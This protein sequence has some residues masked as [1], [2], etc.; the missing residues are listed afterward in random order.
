VK[1]LQPTNNTQEAESETLVNKATYRA[2]R[3][4]TLGTTVGLVQ[5]V[6]GSPAND[7]YGYIRK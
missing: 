3:L 2:P 6:T 5:G 4:V 7:Y 1:A